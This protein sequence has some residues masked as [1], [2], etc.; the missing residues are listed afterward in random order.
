MQL[1]RALAVAVLILH[2]LWIGWVIFGAVWTRRRRALRW[3]HI[4]SLVYGIFIEVVPWP[5]CPLTLLEQW[6][7]ARAGVEPYQGSFILHY[8]DAVVYPNVPV[9]LLIVCAVAVCAFNLGLYVFR[10]R[11]RDTQGW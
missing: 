10:Y 1:Y 9:T 5:P 3:F 2:L 6:L 8:L 7:E 11:H 4:A